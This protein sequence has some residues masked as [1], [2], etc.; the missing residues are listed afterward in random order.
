MGSHKMLVLLSGLVTL[1]M[2]AQAQTQGNETVIQQVFLLICQFI[3]NP[4]S[5]RLDV[6]GQVQ[7]IM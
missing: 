2:S 7:V 5:F 6:G 4:F 3:K 1:L